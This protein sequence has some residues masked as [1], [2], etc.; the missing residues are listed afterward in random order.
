MTGQDHN[1][2]INEADHMKKTLLVWT[3][4]LLTLAVV[5]VLLYHLK[6]EHIGWSNV[7]NEIL[8]PDTC[9][10]SPISQKDAQP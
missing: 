7:C 10:K 6:D 4:M 9:G 1:H 3:M 2:G 8:Y 5:F